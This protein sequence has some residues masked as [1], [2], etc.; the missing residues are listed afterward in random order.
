MTLADIYEICKGIPV[1]RTAGLCA[2]LRKMECGDSIVI[3]LEQHA[4][5][6]TCARRVGAKVKTRNTGE[7][8]VMVW[9][10]DGVAQP[11]VK[12]IFE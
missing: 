8:T 11:A 9:R 3:P 6:H 1:G 5:V 12:S 4:S 7:G 2:T 10:V